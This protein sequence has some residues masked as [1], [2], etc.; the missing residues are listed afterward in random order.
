[1]LANPPVPRP[2]APTLPGEAGRLLTTR[3]VRTEKEWDA[4]RKPWATLY[5]SSPYASTP[6]DFDWLRT[7]WGVYCNRSGGEG[8]RIVT[9][10][11]DAE[12]VGVAPLYVQ[13]GSN[14]SQA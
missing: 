7:W 11:R 5:E 2:H 14:Y 1:M 6:L 3:I 8:L 10:W 4:I 9:V 12:L 13:C